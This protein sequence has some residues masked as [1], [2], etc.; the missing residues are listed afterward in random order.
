M[1]ICGIDEAGRGPVIGPLVTAGVLIEEKDQDKLKA[2]GV[3]DSKL[4][5]P[6][7]RE[8]LFKKIIAVVKDYTIKI[9]QPFQIDAALNDPDSNLNW[10]E[11]D[12]MA[13]ITNELKPDKVIVDCPSNNIKSFTDYLKKKVKTK[14]EIIAE[15]KADF[16]Y[17]VVSAASIL[18]KVTRDGEIEKIKHKIKE[19]IG[20]GY[21]ADPTTQEFLKKNYKKHPDIFRKTWASYLRLTE[22]KKQK[23]LKDF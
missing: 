18:A 6:E 21:P 8:V 5:T 10:L 9:I 1:L 23:S 4:L 22:T 14:T 12:T 3:K 2:L 17:P 11:A 13:G 16:K 7:Q 19:D 15:H 20:S